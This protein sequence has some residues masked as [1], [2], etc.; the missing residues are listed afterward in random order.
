M[1]ELELRCGD[2]DFEGGEEGAYKMIRDD[3]VEGVVCRR[4]GR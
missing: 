2:D 1:V 4:K 3:A